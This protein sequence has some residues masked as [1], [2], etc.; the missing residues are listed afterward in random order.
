MSQLKRA[1]SIRAP[2]NLAAQI[3][4]KSRER[5]GSATSPSKLMETLG[6]GST[7]EAE[8]S[9]ISEQSTAKELAVNSH[10]RSGNDS[11]EVKKRSE[12][13]K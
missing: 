1:N 13:L 8:V 7:T 11:S 3:S 2:P 9:I 10:Q 5:S 12:P 6:H 4:S